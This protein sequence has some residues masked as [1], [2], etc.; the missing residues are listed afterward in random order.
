MNKTLLVITRC[1][2]EYDDDFW[3]FDEADPSTRLELGEGRAGIFIRRKSESDPFKN[4]VPDIERELRS[5]LPAEVGIILHK[6]NGNAEARE[7]EA[8]LPDEIR[9]RL[10]FCKWYSGTMRAF[11]DGTSSPNELPYNALR[12]SVASKDREEDAFDRIW[13]FFLGDQSL[14]VKLELLHACLHPDSIP[15]NLD[16]SLAGHETAFKQFNDARGDD[17]L[18]TPYIDALT[19]LRVQ[20]LGS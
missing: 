6:L 20:L 5:D 8:N 18:A 14:E 1:V 11:W 4:Y 16:P 19:A 7:L 3:D 9:A 10:K 2:S 13:D 12:A 17:C 15:D